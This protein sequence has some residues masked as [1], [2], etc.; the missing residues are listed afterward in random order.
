MSSNKK[1]WQITN[2]SL[3]DL[4][5][6]EGRTADEAYYAMVE[7]TGYARNSDLWDHNINELP[8]MAVDWDEVWERFNDWFTSGREKCSEC[9]GFI[10][11]DRDDW[12]VQQK[13][14]QNIVESYLEKTY[15]F[16][17]E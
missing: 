16:E 1:R 17:E 10:Y 5:I 4:G 12:E 2:S 7:V 8:P 11:R 14:I 15:T 6:W 13:A 3:E 9:N